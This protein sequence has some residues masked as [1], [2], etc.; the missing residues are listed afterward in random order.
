MEEY[1]RHLWQGGQ[2]FEELGFYYVGPIDGH[3]LGQLLPVLKNVRDA[4]QGPILVHVVT[5]KGKGYAPAEASDDKYHGVNKFNV[6]TGAQVKPKPNAPT[7]TRVFADSLIQAAEKD[8]KVVAITAAMPD[9]TGLDLF[10]AAF[11]GAHVRRRHRRAACRDVCGGPC[12]GGLQAVR[13]HL[14]DVP[15]ARLRPGDPRRRDP[16]AARAL[17]A[18][19]RRARRRG[20]RDACRLVRHR[21][22]RLRAELH[23]HGRGGRSRADA[24]GGDAGGD[25]RLSER[26]ALS[27]RRR[28]R[29]RACPRGRRARDRQG[30]RS[31]AKARRWRCSRSARG[32]AKP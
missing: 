1:T 2:W 21:L 29:R 10:G 3:D 12:G 28:R 27:A 26:A 13:G 17:R 22:S 23:H 9:G 11:S 25:R 19:S 14:F 8:D 6:V 5:K 31:C 20:R 24:H 7:Y 18:R 30:P 32:L 16:E 4:K 15:A